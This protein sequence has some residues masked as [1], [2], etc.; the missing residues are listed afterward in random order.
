VAKDDPYLTGD[1]IFDQVSLALDS[2]QYLGFLNTLDYMTNFQK[3][4]QF[5]G[6]RP[7]VCTTTT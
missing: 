6:L 1:L 4:E 5:R 7:D 2:E 3:Y